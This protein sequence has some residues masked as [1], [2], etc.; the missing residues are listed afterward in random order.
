VI[1]LAPRSLPGRQPG[2]F[3][4]AEGNGRMTAI[5]GRRRFLTEG[6]QKERKTNGLL[7]TLAL[8]RSGG[9]DA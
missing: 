9:G 6:C 5:P 4:M 8:I 1:G 2:K 7:S 3:S